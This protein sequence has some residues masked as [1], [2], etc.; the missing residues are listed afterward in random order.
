MNH[1]IWCTC[2]RV[3]LSIGQEGAYPSSMRTEVPALGSFPF[4]TSPRVSLH[5]LFICFLDNILY[6]KLA[7]TSKCPEFCEPP[8][9]KLFGVLSKFQECKGVLNWKFWKLFFNKFLSSPSNLN[10]CL[11]GW[12]DLLCTVFCICPWKENLS[13]P[14]HSFAWDPIS[15]VW[16]G[17]RQG[18]GKVS[19]HLH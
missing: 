15:E 12:K 2:G 5:L 4:H 1:K 11:V 18:L 16:G 14:G 6:I 10:S 13:P 9:T 19:T 8:N 3:C 7:S 17:N